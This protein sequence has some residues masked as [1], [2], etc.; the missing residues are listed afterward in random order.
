MTESHTILVNLREDVAIR[1]INDMIGLYG[2]QLFKASPDGVVL[3]LYLR[4]S[5]D[6]I[7]EFKEIFD[8]AIMRICDL[9]QSK[10][11]GSFI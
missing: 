8:W 4:L 2:V 11:S 7:G 9:D 6:E 10:P 1:V 3:N 5:K